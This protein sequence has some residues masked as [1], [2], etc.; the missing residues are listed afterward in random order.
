VRG[1]RQEPGVLF[2]HLSTNKMYRREFI[3]RHTLRFPLGIHYEDQLFS[4][5]AYCLARAFTIVPD[6]VYR[7]YISPF[8]AADAL[9]ISNQRHRIENVRDRVNVAKLIDDFLADS[10]HQE[11]KADK[12]YKFLKHDL[13]MY[14]GDLPYRTQD[15]IKQFNDEVS[16]YLD[17]LAPE[18][19]QRLPRDQRVVIQLVRDGRYEEAQLA[20]RGMGRGAG[21]REVT[22]DADG[23][24]YW[25][26]V[27]P[28]DPDSARELEITDLALRTRP[29]RNALLRHEITRVA[30]AP[31]AGIT[32]D[33][34]TYDPGNQLPMGPVV[35]TIHL[36]P[37]KKRLSTS[38]RLD[39]VR[40]GLFEGTVT[41]DLGAVPR[42][43]HGF[44]GLRHPVLAITQ[45]RQH[46]TGLLLAPL[47][48]PK[49]SKKISRRGGLAGHRVT[50]EP[51]GHGG[52]R[53]Q[54][55]WERA[56]LLAKAEPHL[57]RLRR[58]AGPG[59]RQARG[60]V[61]GLTK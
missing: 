16:P 6:P 52:G 8:E 38:F 53:I 33:V 42:P 51:E 5:Q 3:D 40:P 30:P 61:R 34:R 59:L 37:T 36:A 25:G 41:I 43:P 45:H 57:P 29:F 49:L 19:F 10:G 21:P 48:F 27:A 46:N 47:D 1:I 58:I 26:A 54:V 35:A 11:I 39:P 14:T 28:A 17:T 60:L 20:S 18:A 31:G 22:E 24:V 4:A 2:E 50:V 12:D 56:G 32:L 9:S 15:W 13:R 44:A 7:W 23:H 55:V